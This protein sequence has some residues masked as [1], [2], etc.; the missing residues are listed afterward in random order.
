MVK[1]NR[2]RSQFEIK[3]SQDAGD[4][5]LELSLTHRK[6]NE[7]RLLKPIGLRI[8]FNE[9]ASG[10]L[11]SVTFEGCNVADNPELSGTLPLTFLIKDLLKHGSLTNKEITEQLDANLDSV[12]VITHR[13]G[14]KGTLIKVG[15]SWGLK[16]VTG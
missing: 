1:Y 15:D 2:S 14:K 5:F 13:L 4:D 8:N 6:H 9:S 7:G 10:E 11:E 3:K 12:R 16:Q